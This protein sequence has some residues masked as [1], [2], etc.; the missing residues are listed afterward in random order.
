MYDEFRKS[1][2]FQR[3]V[4][5]ALFNFNAIDLKEFNDINA[6]L[7]KIK[8]EIDQEEQRS[9]PFRLRKFWNGFIN[10]FRR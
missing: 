3:N 9:W 2:E 8:S 1:I 6:G 5:R 4:V 7:D 10:F